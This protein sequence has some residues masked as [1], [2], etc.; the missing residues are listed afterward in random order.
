LRFGVVVTPRDR[1]YRWGLALADM[2]PDP[3]PAGFLHPVVGY[4][5]SDP[6]KRALD[7]AVRLMRGRAGRIDV[8]YVAH[9]SSVAMLSP[10]AIAEIEE[11]FDE[12]EQE[13]R[14]SAAEQLHDT[15]VAWEFE[16]RQGI[17]TEELVAAA[18]AIHEAH[19]DDPVTIVV[20][21]SSQAAHRL[22]GSVA[23]SLARHSPVPIII[24]P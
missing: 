2:S 13:L 16:R 19:P 7:T 4:D 14:A 17:I 23:V 21:S 11:S 3:A 5:G 15:G 24:V 10:G 20:G 1:R 8:V 12:V 22:L 9:L 18:T 6:A